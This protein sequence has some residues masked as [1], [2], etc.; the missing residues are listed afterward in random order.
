MHC[1]GVTDKGNVRKKNEDYCEGFI[2]NDTLFLLVADGFG[3]QDDKDGQSAGIIACNEVKRYIE[4]FYD[5]LAKENLTNFLSQC[6]YAANRAI[7]SYK[8]ADFDKYSG[9]GSSIT[10]CAVLPT[11]ETI[12][13]HMGTTRVYIIRNGQAIQAT[14]DHTSAQ[15]LLQDNKISKDEYMNHPERAILT[16]GL[17]FSEESNPDLLNI[18]LSKDDILVL[19]TDGVYN[20]MSEQEIAM[21]I[22]EAG[23]TKTA[24]ELFIKYAKERGGFDNLTALVSYINF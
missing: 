4:R 11:R 17:G 15:K 22:Q 24:A 6:I 10:V 9:L 1:F 16:N 23:N 5:T 2:K 8:Q 18:T 19:L 12:V 14:T 21:V 3:I 13:G 7:G 20:L